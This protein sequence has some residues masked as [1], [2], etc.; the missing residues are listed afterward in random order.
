MF[1][2]MK[3]PAGRV[4]SQPVVWPASQ[5]SGQVASQQVRYSSQP[6]KVLARWASSQAAWWQQS[7]SM[8]NVFLYS[9]ICQEPKL[10]PAARVA[11]W[12]WR[13]VIFTSLLPAT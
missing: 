4:A 1:C 5:A 7:S 8:T 13:T 9:S 6:A 10:P 11:S 12:G 2:G 3:Q